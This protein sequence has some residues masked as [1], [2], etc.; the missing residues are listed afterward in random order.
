MQVNAKTVYKFS[1]FTNC[2]TRP[3]LQNILV[4]PTEL[5]ATDSYK[6][7]RIKQNNDITENQ[8]IDTVGF[9]ETYKNT[10][11]DIAVN[12]ASADKEHF[13]DCHAII[14]DGKTPTKELC[15][16]AKQLIEALEQMKEGRVLIKIYDDN[17]PLMIQGNEE[18]N[19]NID[20][21]IMPT[22]KSTF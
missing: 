18:S 22:K 11:K 6:L 1:K 8:L 16:S 20:A 14:P 12:T 3:V 19:T 17:A 15:F 5:I 21:L 13:P 4:T 9:Y 2:K 10:N 7:L